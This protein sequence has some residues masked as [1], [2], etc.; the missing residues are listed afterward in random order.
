ML[1]E[2]LRVSEGYFQKKKKKN[3]VGAGEVIPRG[4]TTGSKATSAT[5]SGEP[6]GLTFHCE[7][8][9]IFPCGD[10]LQSLSSDR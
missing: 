3:K 10:M 5:V 4:N 6:H 2:R 8:R 9:F 1:S 7:E